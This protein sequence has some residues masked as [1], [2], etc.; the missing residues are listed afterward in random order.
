MTLNEVSPGAMCS[1]VNVLLEGETGQRLLDMG[2]VPGTQI[3]VV[4]N[5]PLRD[6]IDISIKGYMLALR[7]SEAG[8]IE[9]S[10]L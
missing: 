8:K 3:K 5:A 4:R 2:F 7:R 6:P 9:V 10:L 1:V